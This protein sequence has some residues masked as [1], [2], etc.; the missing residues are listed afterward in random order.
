MTVWQRSL[1]DLVQRLAA[2]AQRAEAAQ[3]LAHGLGAQRVFLYVKDAALEAM[4]PAPGMPKTVLGGPR[5]RQFLRRCL[6][7]A[8]PTGEVD[9]EQHDA[10]PARAITHDGAALIVVGGDIAPEALQPIEDLFPLLAAV[11]HA[12][13]AAHIER[14]E[15]AE[16]REAAA[17]AADLARAL[18]NA[19]ASA[20]ELNLQLRREHERKDEFLAMLAHELRNP[21]SPLVNSIEILRRGALADDGATARQL[22]V[23]GRQLQQLT[24]LVDDLLDVSRVSRGLVELRRERVALE[25]ILDD[26]VEA[27][28]PLIESRAHV[29]QRPDMP[30][31]LVVNG[32]RVRLTQVFANLL[33]N[34]A[35]YTPAGGRIAISVILDGTRA[36]IVV[37]DNGVGIP[38]EQLPRIFEMFTQLHP[39]AAATG[40]LGIGLT[41]VRRIVELHGGRVSAYSRGEGE[42]S[43]FTVSL[44]QVRVAPAPPA[45]EAAP[46]TE[47]RGGPGP[48]AAVR[49]LVVD[50]NQDAAQSM[51]TLIECM[52]GQARTAH[53]ALE[54]VAVAQEF[55]PQLV[56]LDIGLP[57]IDGYETAR[58]LRALPGLRARIVA[59]TGYAG[60]RERERSLV[61]GFDE[62]LVKPLQPE[63]VEGLLRDLAP[64]DAGL[65][66]A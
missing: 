63:A 6:R 57:G 39:S 15:A 21:L 44:P 14:A 60:A 54:A 11:L 59:L 19:R 8:Q 35:R 46:P 55:A 51:A 49:V 22:D 33:A 2:P 58:R 41:L 48:G 50:D 3:A 27:V 34:A 65:Q 45:P 42:G 53:E 4:L 40:G 36:S 1:R 5:W 16:A 9:L 66:R 24:R 7:E 52:G 38:Q 18:D 10:W 30:A 56:L 25:D 43:T 62:H 31:G 37:K 32:D 23:M 20:G 12:Q 28:R 61:A 13:Q 17:R 29:L 47:Q 26:A 64:S